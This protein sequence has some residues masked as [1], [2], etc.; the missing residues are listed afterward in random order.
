MADIFDVLAAGPGGKPKEVPLANQDIFQLLTTGQQAEQ[1]RIADSQE[2]GAIYQRGA[3][4]DNPV[5]PPESR[6]PGGAIVH[7]INAAPEAIG[8][9]A[10]HAVQSAVEP[11]IG[12]TGS[13]IAGALTSEGLQYFGPQALGTG[14]RLGAKALAHVLPGTQGGKMESL[15]SKTGEAL[16]SGL[17]RAQRSQQGFERAVGKIP[18]GESTPLR[19][20][21]NA[22]DQI[23]AED[24]AHNMQS[25]VG[26]DAQRIAG[27]IDK[28]G[29]SKTLSWIDEEL[30]NIGEKTKQVLGQ[31][32]PDPRYKQLFAAMSNDLE[33]TKPVFREWQQVNANE[34]ATKAK[35][36][37]AG[38][39]HGALGET[40]PA[41]GR[42]IVI[43]AKDQAVRRTKGY[44]DIIDEFNAL[45]KTKRGLGGAQDINGNQLIDR[46]RKNEFLQ[47]SLQESDWKELQPILEKLADAKPLPPPGGSNYG[48]GPTLKRAAIAGGVGSFFGLAPGAAAVG[49]TAL[50]SG[51]G[52]MLM[53]KEG[54]SL[55]KYVLESDAVEKSQ[56]W[57]VLN[58]MARTASGETGGK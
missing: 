43:K 32:N 48:S 14:A 25:P 29:G 27:L 56:K 49:V 23:L 11:Y 39:P 3:M 15:I 28:A 8:Q 45:V 16:Q 20:T 41:S 24:R 34:N 57:N 35:M 12:G 10:G 40:L 52:H 9:A 6:G 31:P 38:Q 33:N 44:E 36:V 47:G 19:N 4:L 30:T 37:P 7:A 13:D 42:G 46:L 50:H 54:R 26:A 22:I 1:K 51:V 5:V 21:R 2:R 17:G 18:A 53:T 58:A 55:V